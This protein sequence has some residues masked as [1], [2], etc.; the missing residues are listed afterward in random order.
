MMVM[1]ISGLGCPA[2]RPKT[3]FVAVC[4]GLSRQYSV[5]SR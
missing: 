3:A 1:W 5:H 2:K 4:V